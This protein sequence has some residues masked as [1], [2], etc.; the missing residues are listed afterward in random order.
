MLGSL[1]CPLDADAGG[2]NGSAARSPFSTKSGNSVKC[3]RA[4]FPVAPLARL[5]VASMDL[6]FLKLVRSRD[7]LEMVALAHDSGRLPGSQRPM[8]RR[9]LHSV[10]VP[11]VPTLQAA[12]TSPESAS[13]PGHLGLD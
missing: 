4:I 11:V 13:S 9:H 5:E 10:V 12:L 1:S 6:P 8:K 3:A 7:D 2:T